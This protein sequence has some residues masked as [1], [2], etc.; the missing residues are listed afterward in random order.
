[1]ADEASESPKGTKRGL[2]SP[3]E[4]SRSPKRKRKEPSSPMDISPEAVNSV[5]RIFKIGGGLHFEEM[6]G[7]DNDV[8]KPEIEA[9]PAI[10]H[11][12]VS[13][14]DTASK[15][16]AATQLK[17][18]VSKGHILPIVLAMESDIIPKLLVFMADNN[19]PKLQYMSTSIIADITM[20]KNIEL[21]L[22]KD[23]ISSMTNILCSDSI[24]NNTT[25]EEAVRALGNIAGESEKTRFLVI[26]EALKS[27]LNLYLKTPL[28]PDN[29]SLNNMIQWT[30]LMLYNGTAP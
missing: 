30:I 27:L 1:M 11:S 14:E 5:S 20:A 25:K 21:L 13:S 18:L 28:G 6:K 19:F 2:T 7:F 16:E 3:R 9:F 4:A 10:V 22:E 26:E 24:K 15:T 8:L 23:V 17:L 12:M 29:V